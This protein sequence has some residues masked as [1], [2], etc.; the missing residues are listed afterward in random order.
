M[1][2]RGWALREGIT[3]WAEAS[4]HWGVRPRVWFWGGKP[5]WPGLRIGEVLMEDTDITQLMLKVFGTIHS[6]NEFLW[7]S[8]LAH[9]R[10]GYRLTS[11]LY[12][13]LTSLPK[14]YKAQFIVFWLLPPTVLPAPSPA[15]FWIL[16]LLSFLNN[17]L[18]AVSLPRK[19][20]VS[21]YRF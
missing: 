13:K 7:Y 15:V 20:R 16:S 11:L 12:S 21:T 17:G 4:H 19:L 2:S 1:G 5:G 10:V 8:C 9:S 3:S 6:E 14:P 18:V